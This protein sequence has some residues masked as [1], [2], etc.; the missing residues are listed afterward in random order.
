MPPLLPVQVP[1]F[2]NANMIVQ[3]VGAI[4]CQHGDIGDAGV[5]A[6]AQGKINDAVL[7]R[8]R[9]RGLGTLLR[10]ETQPLALAPGQNDGQHFAHSSTHPFYMGTV[11]SA[12]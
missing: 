2:A 10:K 1:R 12:H 11:P 5:D 4:L 6:V 9:D 8:E 7:A 3:R